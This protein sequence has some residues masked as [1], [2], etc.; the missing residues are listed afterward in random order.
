MRRDAS[1]WRNGLSV[2]SRSCSPRSLAPGA[3]GITAMCD[4][5]HYRVRLEFEA[6]FEFTNAVDDNKRVS[7][8]TFNIARTRTAVYALTTEWCKI[9]APKFGELSLNFPKLADWLCIGW[10]CS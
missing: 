6:K 4:A 1:R 5:C 7:E 9:V 8:R 3:N 10:L 2:L